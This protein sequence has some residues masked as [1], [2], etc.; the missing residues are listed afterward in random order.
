MAKPIKPPSLSDARPTRG[1]ARKCGGRPYPTDVDK[2]GAFWCGAA[3]S[4]RDGGALQPVVVSAA[5][6]PLEWSWQALRAPPLGESVVPIDDRA[7]WS[8]ADPPPIAARLWQVCDYARGLPPP[9][10]QVLG[11]LD[12]DQRWQAALARAPGV[13]G[14]RVLMSAQHRWG[15]QLWGQLVMKL[16]VC[17]SKP[18]A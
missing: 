2:A 10:H 15:G 16:F 4:W 7:P 8:A 5:R 9:C 12:L 14:W 3:A 13:W 1:R 6:V 18:L 17:P 11:A